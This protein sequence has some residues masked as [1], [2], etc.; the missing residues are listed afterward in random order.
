MQKI[1]KKMREKGRA[2]KSGDS[3]W[4]KNPKRNICGSI[5]ILSKNFMKI[6]PAVFEKSRGHTHTHK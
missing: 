4:V 6:G 2:L 5:R 1:A 3:K